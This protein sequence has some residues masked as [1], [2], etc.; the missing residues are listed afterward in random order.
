MTTADERSTMV[1]ELTNLICRRMNAGGRDISTTAI[2]AAADDIVQAGWRPT[3]PY[4]IF[5]LE[6]GQ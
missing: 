1:L 4:I 6:A 2:E 5:M 3:K